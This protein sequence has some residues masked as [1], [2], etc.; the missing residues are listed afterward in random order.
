MNARPTIE[1][2]VT[3][4]DG[5]DRITR[6]GL[7]VAGVYII[8]GV[9]G[10]G[11]TILANEICYRH[12]A[13]G[14]RA[15]YATLLAESHSRMLQHLQEMSFFDESMVPDRLFYFSAFAT[16]EEEGLKGLLGLLRR[17]MRA[18]KVGL[19]VLDGLVAAQESAPTAR[20]FKK[21]IH[22]LQS[23]A[24]S[25][26]CTVLLLTSDLGEMV[27][28]EHTM[29][30]GLIELGDEQY[31]VRNQRTLQVR[32]FRGA[33][34]LRGR[35][36]FRITSEGIRL[37]PRI[38]ALYDQPSRP[39]PG[40]GK[41]ITSGSA[42][43][44]SMLNGGICLSSITA[45]LGSTGTG[46]T[47]LSTQFL[48]RSTADEPGLMFTFYETPERLIDKARA[49][50]H[51]ITGLL[52]DGRLQILWHS[53]G[54][55]L[56]DEL[57]HELLQ[58]VEARGVRR[59]VIDGLGALLEAVPDAERL[60]RFLSCLMNELRARG[61]ATL[62]TVETREIIGSAVRMPID[63]MSAIVDNV[64][65]LRFVERDARLSRLLSIIK[66]RNSDYDPFVREVAITDTGMVVGEPLFG[67]EATT[68]GVA[69]SVT[70]HPADPPSRR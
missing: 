41:R 55:H 31:N 50:G 67:F 10:A 25:N 37:F 69:R 59:L 38:E 1:R 15:L 47:L 63:G 33:A 61:V 39:D 20:Q 30:D 14:G 7:L 40:H 66:M 27:H 21:F 13:S 19:L 43:L 51:D 45:L 11:K 60:S 5:F 4:V 28:A 26:D 65:Y 22:E 9:P 2:F 46:K 57:A 36:T 18:R 29:V 23:H 54:E 3:G 12:V 68:T 53:Q 32:K 42:S 8:Q 56:I 64:V 62:I 35:H 58:A 48:A 24:A 70:G 6:G 44:D 16:L 34:S 49:I 17:E 52:D